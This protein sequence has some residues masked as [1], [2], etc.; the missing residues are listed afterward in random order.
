MQYG[1]RKLHRSMTEMRRSRIGRANV[2][3]GAGSAFRG[4]MT[5]R[6]DTAVQS[7]RT[8]GDKWLS[9]EGEGSGGF[10]QAFKVLRPAIHPRHEPLGVGVGARRQLDEA[11]SPGESR[12]VSGAVG[13]RWRRPG[14]S[15]VVL[16]EAYRQE[17]CERR[18]HGHGRT[19][20]DA[21]HRL[22]I[23]AEAAA[24][25]RQDV[26]RSEERRVGKECRSRWSPYH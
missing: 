25:R 19:E 10:P 16:L 11:S 17:V 12:E 22:R 2:S 14:P 5:S 8:A 9:V 4:T 23:L 1:Q 20:R 26:A 15:P 18:G 21:L 3:R 24:Q 13:G 6:L 7:M